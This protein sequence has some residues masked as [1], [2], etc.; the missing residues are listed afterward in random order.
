MKTV[1]VSAFLDRHA[2]SRSPHVA[3]IRQ[4]FE[5]GQCEAQ[6][7]ELVSCEE[8]L[9][10]YRIKAKNLERFPEKAGLLSDVLSFLRN[11]EAAGAS[12][13]KMMVFETMDGNFTVVW[14]GEDSKV[15]L[16][17]QSFPHGPGI[18]SML[19]K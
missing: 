8:I 17:A 16:G 6:A 11:L 1:S 4:R 14:E 3:N 7:G 15:I 2:D 13:C 10:T 5:A 9:A 12:R 19:S 18:D